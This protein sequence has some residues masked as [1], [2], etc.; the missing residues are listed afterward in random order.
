[1][2]SV[3]GLESISRQHLYRTCRFLAEHK[4][5]IEQALFARHRTLFDDT[6]DLVFFDT[7]STYFEGG[8]S[9]LRRYGHSKDH[10]P[11]RV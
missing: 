1:M 5:R 10:R 3:I 9:P 11:D 7:T 8:A 4:V 6:V 2:R